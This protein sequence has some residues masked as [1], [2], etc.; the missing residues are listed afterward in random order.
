MM[1]AV[2]AVLTV[3]AIFPAMVRDVYA[4]SYPKGPINLVIPL[5]P[6]DATD[7]AGRLMGEELSKLL[8]TPI[9]VVNRPG[10]GGTVGVDS[11]VKAAKDGY[12]ILLANNAALTFRRV[13]EPQNVAYDPQKDLTPLGLTTRIPSIIAIRTD[14]PY[15][16][17]DELVE[18]SKR[19]PSKVRVGNV[20]SGSVGDFA[21]QMIN[22]LTGSQ[23][24]PIP[25]KGAAPAIAALRGGHVEGVAVA[26]GA[27]AGQLKSGGAHGVVLSTRFPE[28]PNIPTMVDLKHKQNIPGVWFG[29]FAPAGIPAEATSALVA[30]VQRAASDPGIAGKLVPLG[31][32]QDYGAPQKLVAEISDEFRSVEQMARRAGLIK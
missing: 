1:K 6:G 24:T 19:N 27:I 18:Y 29:F 3:A 16:T 4:Q 21:V 14:A 10:A 11:V 25:F 23:L 22:V 9:V 2:L 12:T 7:I 8:K 28:F 26:L 15:K 5:A 20:G 30:A 31:M 32:V 17:L 13:L